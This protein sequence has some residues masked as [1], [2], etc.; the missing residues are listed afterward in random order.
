M[1][2]QADGGGD[3]AADREPPGPRARRG[4][5]ARRSRTVHT[6]PMAIESAQLLA[7]NQKDTAPLYAAARQLRG[8]LRR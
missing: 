7:R 2:R 4:G 3:R 8:L 6:R 1:P 5:P